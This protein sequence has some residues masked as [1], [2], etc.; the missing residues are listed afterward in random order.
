[1]LL[2]SAE[3]QA[4]VIIQRPSPH[5]M[6]IGWSTH[7]YIYLYVNIYLY[8]QNTYNDIGGVGVYVIHDHEHVRCAPEQLCLDLCRLLSAG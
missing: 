1:M 5:I 3:R 8:T 6:P 7:I 4:P 2:A